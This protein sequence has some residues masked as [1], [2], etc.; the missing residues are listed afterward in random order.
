MTHRDLN[1]LDTFVKNLWVK[2]GMQLTNPMEFDMESAEYGACCFELDAKKIIFRVAKTTPTK[3]GQFLTL[4]KRPSP[5][6]EIAPYDA[7]DP[8]DFL[9]IYTSNLGES[10]LFVFSRALLT[11]MGVLSSSAHPGKRAFRVY[12]P[13]SIPIAKQAVKTQAWQTKYFLALTADGAYNEEFGR[14]LFA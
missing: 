10:G 13:W 7:S 5:S 1:D 11:K 6:A 9:V 4:W 3:I 2:S 12:P 14:K 8:F